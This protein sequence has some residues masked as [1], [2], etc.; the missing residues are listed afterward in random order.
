MRKNDQSDP[1]R[2]T[3]MKQTNQTPTPQYPSP[4]NSTNIPPTANQQNYYIPTQHE[5]IYFNPRSNTP[6]RVQ[7]NQNQTNNN[8]NPIVNNQTPQNSRPIRNDVVN[9]PLIIDQRGPSR[10]MQ[11]QQRQRRFPAQQRTRPTPNG[12][13]IQNDLTQPF[14]LDQSMPHGSDISS[15]DWTRGM[16]N[17]KYLIDMEKLY[18]KFNQR[19]NEPLQRP[20]QQQQQEEVIRETKNDNRPTPNNTI[21]PG[22]VNPDNQLAPTNPKT[23][24]GNQNRNN[25]PLNEYRIHY[26]GTTPNLI[27]QEWQTVRQ[28]PQNQ[29]RNSRANSNP[30][31]PSNPQGNLNNYY[32]GNFNN[33]TPNSARPTYQPVSAPFNPVSRSQMKKVRKSKFN[34][35]IYFL[36]YHIIKNFIKKII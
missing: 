15:D 29:T 10:Q 28:D 30:R 21:F 6:T 27:D 34:F 11:T 23:Q 17:E 3:Q 22:Q 14:I 31:R 13:V 2:Q 35:L 4:P 16:D 1:N 33:Q 32:Q 19:E 36:E 26:H 5:F 18:Q 20:P 12:H 8:Q 25:Q 24:Q 9:Q 7:S